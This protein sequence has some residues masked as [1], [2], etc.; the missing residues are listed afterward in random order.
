MGKYDKAKPS[1]EEKW[2]WPDM[3]NPEYWKR[4]GCKIEEMSKKGRVLSATCKAQPK[5]PKPE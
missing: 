1:L 5:L 3:G 4:P 2:K